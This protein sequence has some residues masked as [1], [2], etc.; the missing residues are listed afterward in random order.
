MPL[1]D[2]EILTKAT[3]YFA[4]RLP[5][6]DEQTRIALFLQS[7]KSANSMTLA[8]I[9]FSSLDWLPYRC[10]HNQYFK[11]MELA[12]LL[13]KAV[14]WSMNPFVYAQATQFNL[15]VWAKANIQKYLTALVATDDSFYQYLAFSHACMAEIRFMPL[16]PPTAPLDQ[17]FIHALNEIEVE[18]GRQIQV[19]IRLLKDM[20]VALTTQDREIIIAEQCKIIGDLFGELLQDVCQMQKL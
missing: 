1:I 8:K 14:H 7:L 9:E 3:E 19:Q 11:E 2:R 4:K 13:N 5:N 18:N 20:P 6:A 10:L 12:T 16:F 17:P 15:E